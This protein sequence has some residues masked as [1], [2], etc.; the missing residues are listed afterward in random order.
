MN[1]APIGDGGR[2]VERTRLSWR[3][4]SLS[5]TAVVAIGIFRL[6]LPHPTARTAIGVAVI[7]LAW[8][9]VLAAVERR[10]ARLDASIRHPGV[11]SV[12]TPRRAP[13]T[14]GLL[15]ALAALGALLVLR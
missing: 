14:I 8:L 13:A 3:R 15:V 6:V 11:P 4:T 5:A 1:T 9:G 7:A 10:I 12:G 2:A